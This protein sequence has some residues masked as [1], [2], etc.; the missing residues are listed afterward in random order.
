MAS[1]GISPH[2]ILEQLSEIVSNGGVRF[3][4]KESF[5]RKLK[6]PTLGFMSDEE[7]AEVLKLNDNMRRLEKILEILEGKGAEE[8]ESFESIL[9]ESSLAS[10]AD[11]LTKIKTGWLRCSFRAYRVNNQ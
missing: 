4:V 1:Q 3:Q 9:R 2:R 8:Y 5:V 7:V 10:L 11:E 6:K